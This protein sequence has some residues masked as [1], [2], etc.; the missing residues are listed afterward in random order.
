MFGEQY[1]WDKLIRVKTNYED[2]LITG[3]GQIRLKLSGQGQPTSEVAV[4]F[5]KILEPAA[6]QG[7]T[8]RQQV[9]SAFAAPEHA[10]VFETL[11]HNRFAARLNNTGADEVT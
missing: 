5:P 7:A 11:T 1:N 2:K 9:R 3:A 4:M 8:N 6:E 10:R